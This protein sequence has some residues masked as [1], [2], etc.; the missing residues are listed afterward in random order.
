[1]KVLGINFLSESSVCLIDN[2]KLKYAISEER[3]N[4]IKNWYGIPF[5]SIQHVL[6]ETGNSIKDIDYFAGVGQS[7][8][9][10]DTP[11]LNSFCEKENLIKKSSLSKK[12]KLIQLSFLK[13]I[14]IH[15]RYVI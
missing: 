1:M 11:D 15:E 6:K 4:R 7:A 10:K 13:K 9:S 5:K 14:L 12:K 3:L 8:Y 2:G